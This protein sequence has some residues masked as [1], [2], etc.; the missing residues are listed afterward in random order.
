LSNDRETIET[1]LELQLMLLYLPCQN[2]Q[3]IAL[4]RTGLALVM[5]KDTPQA[6]QGMRAS[7]IVG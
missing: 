5:A 3:A 6:Q 2:P 1:I 7:R 4:L